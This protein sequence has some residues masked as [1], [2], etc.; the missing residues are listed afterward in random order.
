[1]DS[2]SVAAMAKHAADNGGSRC[3]ISAHT[4]TCRHLF[5]YAEGHFAKLAARE[6]GIPWNEFPL[7]DKQ[8]LGYW[9]RPE[10]RRPQPEKTPLFDWALA[11]TLGKP[12]PAKVVLTGQG[13]DGIFSSL[14][15]R[16]CRDRIREGSWW[17]LAGEA[18]R[19]FLSEGRLGRLQLRPHLLR[20]LGRGTLARPFPNWLNPDFERRLNLR[21]QYRPFET[22][23]AWGPIPNGTV[24]PEG[25]GL[26]SSPMWA[27]LFEDYTPDNAGACI[28]ARHPFFDLRLVRYVLTL[29]ALP[30]C[31]DKEL[32]RRSMHGLLPDEIRL[33][34]KRP[35]MS[36]V[37][38]TYYRKS[39][40]PWLQGFE[41]VE[42]LN[43]YVDLH[44]AIEQVSHPAPKELAVHLRPVC[45]NLWLKW[46]SEYAYKVPKEECRAQS[47]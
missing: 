1:M 4:Q 46:E 29:P 45:L 9:N 2:S 17:Q 31:T 41:P 11:D 21:E 27:G 39:P 33:A 35:I 14:R 24:R 22:G 19:Y 16:H 36:N 43:Q 23:T 15:L 26:V 28:E 30:W 6:I 37:L 7:D 8:L 47:R 12:L 32:L 3:A 18:S 25:Y 40:K 34:R 42:E 38:M 20:F 10:F 13:S 5:P 44:R